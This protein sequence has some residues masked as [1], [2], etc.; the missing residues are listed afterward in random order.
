MVAAGIIWKNGKILIAQRAK[1]KHLEGYWEFP[2]GKIR[3]GESS[4]DCL[5][6]ELKEELG[7]T[8]SV[9]KFFMDSPFSYPEKEVCLLAYEVDYVGGEP[10]LRDHDSIRWVEAKEL[11]SFQLAPADRPIAEALSKVTLAG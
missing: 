11:L 6:R 10:E 4:V 8:V 9:R 7:I 5:H 1:G 3:A 2:G